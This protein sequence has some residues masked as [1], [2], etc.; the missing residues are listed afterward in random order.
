MQSR[1]ARSLTRHL[2]TKFVIGFDFAVTLSSP[3][4]SRVLF[5]I[6]VTLLMEL[7]LLMLNK[8]KRWFH[9]SHVKFPFVSMSAS[10]FLVSMY[11]I[12]ILGSRLIPS[13][14]QSRATLRVLETCLIVGLLP[15]VIILITASL[16]SNAYNKASWWEELTFEG[17]KSTSSRSWIIPWDCFR[18]WIVWG[19]ERT[20]CLFINGSHRASLLW[21]LFSWRTATIRSYKSSAGFPSILKRASKEMISDSVELCETEDYFLHIQLI[22][23]K[24]VASQNAQCS[25]WSRFR[26]LKISCKIGVLKQSQSHIIKLF[27]LT[28]MMNVR[29]RTR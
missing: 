29:D 21:F 2:D 20:S 23:K 22:G 8:Q 13:N 1:Q 4:S 12:W 25:T 24:R 10:W 6:A 28:C 11:L 19:V 26:V 16:S 9:S 17:I 15:F 5:D 27:I 7:K 3:A 14:N 18:L